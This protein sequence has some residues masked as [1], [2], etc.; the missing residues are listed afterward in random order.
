MRITIWAAAVAAGLLLT[1]CAA[2]PDT[3]GG[4]VA[5]G[6]RTAARASLPDDIRRAGVLVVGSD[7][8][9]APME[10][11]KDGK[12]TGFDVELAAAIASRLG[13]K[14]EVRQ[15][16]WPELLGKV[17]AGDLDAAMASITDKA[18]RQKSVDFVDYLNVGSVVVTRGGQGGDGIEALCGRRVA[19]P[20]GTLYVDLAEAQNKRCPAGE[21]MTI[22][23]VPT[24]TGSKEMVLAGKADAYLDDFPPAAVSVREN[25]SLAISGR[26]I[27]AAPYGIAI[28]KDRSGLRQAVQLALYELFDDG[29]YD[30]LLDKWQISEG[31]LK[32]GAINGGA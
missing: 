21:K 28:A 22:I 26:Q 15:T 11:V 16:P 3:A 13:L 6:A 7:L 23:A 25:P 5:A 31:S 4:S 32:T 14:A 12:Q 9:F 30:K 24:L 17:E 18:E 10:F 19:L 1:G 27:E 8:S 20:A 2:A 29:T